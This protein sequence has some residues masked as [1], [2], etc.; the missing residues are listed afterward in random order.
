MYGGHLLFDTYDSYGE[1]RVLE[2]GEKRLLSFG[3][4]DEQSAGLKKN[5]A[6][7]VFDYTQ[8]MLLSLLF[9][10]PKKVL[11]LGLGAGSLATCLHQHYARSQLTVVELRQHVIDVAYRYFG[12]PRSKRLQVICGEALETL[13]GLKGQYDIIFSDI[14]LQEGMHH[15]QRNA[16]YIAACRQHLK[17]DGILVTNCWR[18]HQEDNDVLNLMQQHFAA[19]N[20]C[21][22]P[23]NNW[24][25]FASQAPFEVQNSHKENAKQLSKQLGY[26]LNK[27]LKRFQRA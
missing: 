13:Q 5:P 18:E 16:V 7:L 10:E 15:S 6:A 8:A 17:P 12:L 26:S 24:L 22:T 25:L 1:I 27:H 3:P 14:Y 9:R 19:V 11:L 2:Q 21:T 20:T 23:D 4:G